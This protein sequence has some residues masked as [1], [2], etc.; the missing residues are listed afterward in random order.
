MGRFEHEAVS[1]ALNGTALSN[2]GRRRSAR[3]PLPLPAAAPARRTGSLHAGGLSPPCGLRR[4]PGP[5][6]CPDA[7]HRVAVSF[8]PV[9][10]TNPGDGRHP[11]TRTGAGQWRHTDTGGRRH[12]EGTRRKYLVREQPRRRSRRRRS[13]GRQRGQHIRARS[14][15][16]TRES[17]CGACCYLPYG[18]P[19]DG[20]DNITVG[21]HGF[22]LA[23]TDGDDDQWLVGITDDG[24]TF[25]FAFN[26]STKKS[27]PARRSHRTVARSS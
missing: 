13:R 8:V 1:F 14:G 24:R 5:L 7:G 12:V 23:C 18:S 9:P 19:F 25:P 17:E 26:R 20:P 3:M 27:S 6:R 16:T 15:S 4:H 2:R 21:P 22:A 11:D 10:N